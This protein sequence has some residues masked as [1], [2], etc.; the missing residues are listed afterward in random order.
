MTTEGRA[1][2]PPLTEEERLREERF[3]ESLMKMISFLGVVGKL[4]DVELIQHVEE[5]V[6]GNLSTLGMEGCLLN[7]LIRRFEKA[8]GIQKS[9]FLEEW[10]T[11][12]VRFAD[13]SFNMG[14]GHTSSLPEATRYPTR[15]VAEAVASELIDATAVEVSSIPS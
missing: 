10:P 2:K 9:E 7:E 13:G 11:Y 6:G 5:R 12:V 14:E 1:P 8:K 4:S 3:F 15:E